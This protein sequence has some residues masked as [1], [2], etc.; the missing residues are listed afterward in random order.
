M[1]VDQRTKELIAV[2]MAK[3]SEPI[4]IET[5]AVG[6]ELCIQNAQDLWVDASV[7]RDS[8]RLPRA[9]PLLVAAMEELGKISVLSTMARLPS[10]KPELWADAWGDFRNHKSKTTLALVHTYD[11]RMRA[12]PGLLLEAA[13][14]QFA[15]SPLAERLRQVGLYVDYLGKDDGWVSPLHV[16]LPAVNDWFKRVEVV[17]ERVL[18]IH[19]TGLY[20]HNALQIQHEVYSPLNASRPRRKEMTEEISKR[21]FESFSKVH[22]IFIARLISDGILDSSSGL[23]MLGIPAAEFA[24][25]GK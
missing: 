22:P 9:M 15:L 8:S 2:L 19:A 10:N 4:S 6:I 16:D 23:E 12:Y 5:I 21:L 7:L 20:S 24:T 14:M 13:N 25:Q 11:D 17:L 3:H 18:A 1:E